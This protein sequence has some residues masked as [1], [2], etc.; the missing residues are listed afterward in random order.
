MR[1][2]AFPLI[3]SLAA[4]QTNFLTLLLLFVLFVSFVVT[5]QPL[6]ANY[7]LGPAFSAAT[8]HWDEA[9]KVLLKLFQ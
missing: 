7:G 9:Q 3:T 8:D 5:P 4:R 2:A 1:G 6:K